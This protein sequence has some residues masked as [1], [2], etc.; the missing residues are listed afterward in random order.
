MFIVVVCYPLLKCLLLL[1][2]ILSLSS[3]SHFQPVESIQRY[4]SIVSAGLSGSSHMIWATIGG[5]MDRLQV[6][7]FSGEL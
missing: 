4:F 5:A 2:V 6:Y 7:E 1:S 3:S